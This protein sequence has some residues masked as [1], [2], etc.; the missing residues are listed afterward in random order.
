M[1]SE[2]TLFYCV[3]REITNLFE[4]LLNKLNNRLQDDFFGCKV[5]QLLNDIHSSSSSK[6]EDLNKSFL[7]KDIVLSHLVKRKESLEKQFLQ[8]TNNIK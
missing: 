7:E 1:K 2:V 8:L 6:V 3:Q 4:D 5:G